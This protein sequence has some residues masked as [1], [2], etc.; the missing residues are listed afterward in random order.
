MLDSELTVGTDVCL[1]IG[2]AL[3]V[4]QEAGDFSIDHGDIRTE[5]FFIAIGLLL[6]WF[7][8]LK[9]VE[10]S[11]KV[12]QPTALDRCFFMLMLCRQFYML[13]IAIRASFMKTVR[14]CQTD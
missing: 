3:S 9:Y 6:A 10:W 8:M 4:S 7:N 2:S 13:I 5:R 14:L 11:T 12:R 1:L